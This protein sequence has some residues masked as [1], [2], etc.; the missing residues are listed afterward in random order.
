[1][2]SDKSGSNFSG[3]MSISNLT[4]FESLIGSSSK[5]P[6]SESTSSS[7]NP[8]SEMIDSLSSFFP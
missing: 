4:G 7:S 8:S 5:N 2:S 3:S 1:M 6:L